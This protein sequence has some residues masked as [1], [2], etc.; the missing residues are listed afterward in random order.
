MFD[1]SQTEVEEDVL[2]DLIEANPELCLTIKDHDECIFLQS[3]III[4]SNMNV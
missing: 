4:S 1:D 2:L 3:H